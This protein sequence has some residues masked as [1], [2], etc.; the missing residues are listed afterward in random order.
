MKEAE[1]SFAAEKRIF[2]IRKELKGRDDEVENH[3][4]LRQAALGC[5]PRNI[6]SRSNII[7][8]D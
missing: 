2:P 6:I 5:Q 4:G 7:K 8:C 1:N 3:S